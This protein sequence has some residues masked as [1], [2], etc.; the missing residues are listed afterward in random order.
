MN[1]KIRED[2]DKQ[3]EF[4]L[5]VKPEG[6]V[7]I[8]R[9]LVLSIVFIAVVVF[10]WLILSA[11]RSPNLDKSKQK[12]SN[13]ETIQNSVK[14][15][16]SSV[17]AVSPESSDVLKKL[18][19]TYTDKNAIKKYMPDDTPSDVIP[20]EVTQ[21][22][23]ELQDHQEFLQQRIAE[24]LQKK[25]EKQQAATEKEEQELQRA[26]SSNMFFAGI[27]PPAPPPIDQEIKAS[28][29]QSATASKNNSQQ[30]NMTF[31]EHGPDAYTQQNMQLQKLSFLQSSAKDEDVYDKHPLL[32]PISPYEI[33]AGTLIP[34]ELIT[35]INTTLPGSVIAQ[36]KTNVFDSVSGKFLLIPQGSK[37][38]GE[39]QSMV[40]YGQER[41]LIAFTR[42]IR[43]DGSSIQLDKYVGTDQ[44]GQSGMQGEVDNH[45]GRVLGVATLSTLLSV[46]AGVAADRNYNYTGNY[47]F[48]SARQSAILGAASGIS[49]TGQQLTSQ[50][51]NVQPTLT[52]PIGYEFN[53]IVKKD[54]IMEPYKK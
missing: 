19:D 33:Q 7:R 30:N 20:A 31:G 37:L 28:Q 15:N 2:K 49:Q 35:A 36:V 5:K 44:F 42:I 47:V 51:M 46:G 8:N 48:P 13:N 9:V 4:K 53:V 22:I 29:S 52:I 25:I 3:A 6:A 1:Q 21:E 23:K 38:I 34:A 41:V 27:T 17:T 39:Y 40:S 54:M 32:K 11:F 50:A 14:D 45:W 26:R 24:L 43:P 12:L 10:L 16:G 18:P